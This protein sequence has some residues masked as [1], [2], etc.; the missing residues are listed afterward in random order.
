M[1]AFAGDLELPSRPLGIRMAGC[2]TGRHEFCGDAPWFVTAQVAILDVLHLL[3][4]GEVV[5][6]GRYPDGPH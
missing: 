3:S 2:G 5:A 6:Q 4:H 1:E